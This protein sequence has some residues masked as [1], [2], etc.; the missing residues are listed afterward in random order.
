[1]IGLGI[2]KIYNEA[3]ST[4]YPRRPNRHTPDPNL[5]TFA[6]LFL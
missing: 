1:M 2:A 4:I 6:P 3:E 5:T